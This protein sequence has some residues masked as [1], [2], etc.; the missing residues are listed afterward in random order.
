MNLSSQYMPAFGILIL[1]E[2]ILVL[3]PSPTDEAN[4]AATYMVSEYEGQDGS[5][6]LC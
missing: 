4:T 2:H 5:S 1:H 3:T 6:Q